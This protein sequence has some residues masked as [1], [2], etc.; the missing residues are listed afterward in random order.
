MSEYAS[1]KAS[2]AAGCYEIEGLES[3]IQPVAQDRSFHAQGIIPNSESACPRNVPLSSIASCPSACR[4]TSLDLRQ[5]TKKHYSQ[6][7]RSNRPSRSKWKTLLLP[8]QGPKHTTKAV[9]ILLYVFRAVPL[10]SSVHHPDQEANNHISPPPNIRRSRSSNEP[11]HAPPPHHHHRRHR[12]PPLAQPPPPLAPRAYPPAVRASHPHQPQPKQ[13]TLDPR[14][15]RLRHAPLAP[16]ARVGRHRTTLV[17]LVPRH[18]GP[19][20]PRQPPRL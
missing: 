5:I 9:C 20:R 2:I 7:S 11:P 18:G 8:T 16:R 13:S 17:P 3:Y 1:P 15:P 4:M 12:P 19:Q 10:K 14:L 6:P